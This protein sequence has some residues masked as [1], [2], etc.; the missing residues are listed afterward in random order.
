L[1]LAGLGLDRLS[2]G[3]HDALSSCLGG[4]FGDACCLGAHGGECG[5]RRRR[6]GWINLILQQHEEQEED[7]DRGNDA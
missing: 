2:C 3:Q 1:D 7:K 6:R 5:L 4:V